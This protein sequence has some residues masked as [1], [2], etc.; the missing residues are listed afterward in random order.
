[1]LHQAERG[2]PHPTAEFRPRTSVPLPPVSPMSYA[3]ATLHFALVVN[4]FPP[5]PLSHGARQ[6]LPTRHLLHL[7]RGPSR[8]YPVMRVR[9]RVCGELVDQCMCSPIAPFFCAHPTLH[10]H[11][12]YATRRA[13]LIS[14][15]SALTESTPL[16]RSRKHNRLQNI[17]RRESHGAPQLA[18]SSRAFPR[19]WV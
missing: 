10:W 11:S 7:A 9:A 17:Q 15:Y 18:P 1:M 12:D 19:T 16:S 8:Y 13:A 3:T 5:H 14:S 6:P 4:T 2:L